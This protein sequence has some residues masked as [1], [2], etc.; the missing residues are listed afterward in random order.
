MV[1]ASKPDRRRA[2]LVEQSRSLR[3]SAPADSY[4]ATWW[5][6]AAQIEQMVVQR[7]HDA[8]RTPFQKTR[9]CGELD[10]GRDGTGTCCGRQVEAGI[11]D[12][13]EDGRA[14]HLPNRHPHHVSAFAASA[15]AALGDPS[16]ARRRR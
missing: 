5:A 15:S 7:A 9:A 14:G 2:D 16:A 6:N 8:L 1:L 11:A 4:S 12:L 3:L 13:D 10:A